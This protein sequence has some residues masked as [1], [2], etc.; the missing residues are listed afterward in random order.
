[1]CL[2]IPGKIISFEEKPGALKMAKVDFAGSSKNICID[3]LP[4][5]KTGEYVLVHAGFAISKIDEQEAEETLSS[6]RAMGE[7]LEDEIISDEEKIARTRERL[8]KK[9]LRQNS[10]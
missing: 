4:E 9:N 2:A 7:L 10:D 1:M 5:A 3:W 6:L 8:N